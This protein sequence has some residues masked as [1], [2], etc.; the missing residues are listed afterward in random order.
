[1]SSVSLSG[2]GV[3]LAFHADGQAK[4]VPFE[5]TLL[6]LDTAA[7]AGWTRSVRERGPETRPG[8]RA[9][10]LRESAA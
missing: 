2:E 6:R 10:A 7:R 9:S 1:M 4:G 8:G 3:C 5:G